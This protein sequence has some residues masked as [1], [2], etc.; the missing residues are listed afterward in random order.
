M[1]TDE[2]IAA[3]AQDIAPRP[4]PEGRL[5][6][7]I[8]PAL[9]VAAGLMLALLG[10]RDDLAA[11]LRDPLTWGKFVLP[12]VTAGVAL[13]IGLRLGRP[14]SAVPFGLLALPVLLVGLV[15][16]AGYV[17]TP[18]GARQLAWTG[19]TLF[20]CLVSIPSLSLSILA[21]TLW[22]LRSGAVLRPR[23]A[24]AMAG[25][26]AGGMGTLIYA[27]HCTEDSPLF[28]GSWYSLGILITA[29]IGALVAPRV[30][31]W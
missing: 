7:A 6:R 27:T 19:E 31:R 16:L 29:A 13:P 12:A 8:G 1:K 21:A 10:M 11:M 26:F 23:I 4:R 15:L 22:A 3:L 9:I 28:Y 17:A 5:G 30:L 25:L 2:L 18:E 20:A 24:G 14:A